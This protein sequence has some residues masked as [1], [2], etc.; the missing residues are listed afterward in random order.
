MRDCMIL[1]LLYVTFFFTTL[2]YGL[3][4]HIKKDATKACINTPSTEL[5]IVVLICS[6]NASPWVIRNLDSVRMQNYTNWRIVYFDDASEDGTSNQVRKYLEEHTLIDKCTLI[7]NESRGRKLKNL[8]TAF[9]H[10]ITDEEIILQLDGDDW[11]A[12]EQVFSLI[13]TIYQEFDVWMTYGNYQNVPEAAYIGQELAFISDTIVAENNFRSTDMFMQLRTFYGWLAKQIKL[14]DLLSVYVPNFKGNFFPAS[15]DAAT[16]WPMFEMAGAHFAFIE[17]IL[18]YLNRT[19]PLNGFKVDRKLQRKSSAELRR[20][21]PLYTPLLN[22]MYNHL[23]QFT[24]AQ[25]DCFILS[26]NNPE[27]LEQLHAS[28]K[29]H[30]AG[31]GTIWIFYQADSKDLENAY[32]ALQKRYPLTFFQQIHKESIAKF[33]ISHES[34]IGDHILIACDHVMLNDHINL[35]LCIQELERTSASAFYF[36]VGHTSLNIPDQHIWDEI[37]ASKFYAAKNAW[38]NT[39]DMTLMRKQDLIKR[40]KQPHMDQAKTFAHFITLW[41]EDVSHN[42]F[43]AGLFFSQAKVIGQVTSIETPLPE[44]PIVPRLRKRIHNTTTSPNTTEKMTR[45]ERKHQRQ[46]RQNNRLQKHG[47]NALTIP[48]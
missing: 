1:L 32:F 47:N 14:A 36:S 33:L 48:N 16:M 9:H 43:S 29:E 5:P 39:L 28:I 7:T 6:Y 3:P 35:T 31:I 23:A 18:Y 38:F 40:L 10:Y 20:Q 15:N 44:L 11:L 26:Y 12:H 30:A 22:P 42:L 27:G 46:E 19:N 13:N 24:S 25:A 8:Y 41:S 37:Y 2:S 34:R 17:E 45:E 4:I 21:I